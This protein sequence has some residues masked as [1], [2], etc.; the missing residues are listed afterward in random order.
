MSP[1]QRWA[2]AMPAWHGP[3]GPGRAVWPQGLVVSVP[4]GS[5]PILPSRPNPMPLLF[6]SPLSLCLSL[7]GSGV[8]SLFSLQMPAPPKLFLTLLYKLEGPH[9]DEVA[10]ALELTTWD[11]DTCHEGNVTSLPGEDP[12]PPVMLSAVST[13]C[14]A[15]DQLS[16]LPPPNPA[17]S[18]RA[19]RPA[20]PPVPPGT[21]T[22]PR[23]AS[24]RL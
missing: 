10:V 11:S 17:P 12:A 14:G 4:R 5:L 18:G 1:P 2:G 6:L 22:R 7:G 24:C 19:Q 13:C 23:Q 15:R 21:T 16:P 8:I 20:P 9:A 3:R